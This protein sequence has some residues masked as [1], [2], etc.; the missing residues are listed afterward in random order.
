[1]ESTSEKIK[2]YMHNHKSRLQILHRLV[3]WIEYV[4]KDITLSNHHLE[5]EGRGWHRT[6]MKIKKKAAKL[7]VNDPEMPKSL[8]AFSVFFSHSALILI[9]NVPVT[10]RKH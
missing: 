3:L 7:F 9:T 5:K 10:S 4:G 8:K 1:M 2:S 6:A